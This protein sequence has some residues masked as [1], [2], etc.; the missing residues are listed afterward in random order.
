M[1]PMW[2]A[3]WAAWPLEKNWPLE[4][5]IVGFVGNSLLE[6]TIIQNEQLRENYKTRSEKNHGRK[7]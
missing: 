1:R 6:V 5:Q 3:T 7:D 4:K 2:R